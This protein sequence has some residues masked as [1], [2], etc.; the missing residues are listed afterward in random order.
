MN[1]N[2]QINNNPL[3]KKAIIRIKELSCLLKDPVQ[4][5]LHFQSDVNLKN[6]KDYTVISEEHDDNYGSVNGSS[7]I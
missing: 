4:S 2:I 3:T 1:Q 6:K 5:K 7:A